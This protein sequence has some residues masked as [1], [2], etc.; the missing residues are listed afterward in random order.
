MDHRDG[1]RYLRKFPTYESHLPSLYVRGGG[2]SACVVFAI[3]LDSMRFGLIVFVRVKQAFASSRAQP[4]RLVHPC[5]P[6]SAAL[7]RY[8]TLPKASLCTYNQRIQL[9]LRVVTEYLKICPFFS[10]KMLVHGAFYLACSWAR[11]PQWNESLSD[12]RT[13]PH[14]T[15]RRVRAHELTRS[16]AGGGGL[17]GTVNAVQADLLFDKAAICFILFFAANDLE[18]WILPWRQSGS[19]VWDESLSVNSAHTVNCIHSV[20]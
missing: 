13:A 20:V 10:S 16:P 19:Q 4:N 9:S 7:F 3:L 17:S 12:F 6:R 1:A 18:F 5:R 8:K 2:G 11:M 15:Q 14:R